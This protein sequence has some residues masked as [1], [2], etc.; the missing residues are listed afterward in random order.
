[1][2]Y[3]CRSERVGIES[4]RYCEITKR[5]QF[6]TRREIDYKFCFLGVSWMASD[7]ILYSN[8][9]KFGDEFELDRGAYELRR[10]G[11]ALKLGRIPME[12]LL[13]LVER[14][15]Q[16]ITRAEIVEKI[17]GKNVFLDT[18]NSINAAIR[19]LRQTLGDEA[20]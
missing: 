1:M 4:A 7:E 9:T 12:L 8:S 3:H 18:D 16:L 10:A 11:E 19:K 20:E 5:R 15:S 14:P 2:G 13:L 17:W 6:C